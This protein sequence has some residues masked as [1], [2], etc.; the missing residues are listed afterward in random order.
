MKE[1]LLLLL[2]KLQ[3]VFNPVALY[4][5]K[6]QHT[7]N[8]YTQTNTAHKTTQTTKDIQHTMNAMQI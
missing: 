7:N 1:I 4:Y 2:F 5:N 3:I 8:T 6:K